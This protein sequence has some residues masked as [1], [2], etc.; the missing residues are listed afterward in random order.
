MA[1]LAA[2]L[3]DTVAFLAEAVAFLAALAAFFAAV[4]ALEALLEADLPGDFLNF[5]LYDAMHGQ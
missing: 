1:A 2:F 4:L 5:F 3:A